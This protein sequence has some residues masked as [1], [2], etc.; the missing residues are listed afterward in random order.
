MSS[1]FGLFIGCQI[2]DMHEQ[3]LRS[4]PPKI[5][6]I[7][8]E[9]TDICFAYLFEKNEADMQLALTTVSCQKVEAYLWK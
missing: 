2:F 1:W 8:D 7:K 6:Y 5:S 9:R 3:N 4:I